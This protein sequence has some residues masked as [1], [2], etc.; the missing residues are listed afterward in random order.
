MDARPL[1]SICCLT[2]N[3]EN[4]IKETLEGF[5]LQDTNFP[6]EV[7]IHDDASTDKT[8]AIIKEFQEKY[9]TIIK[10]IFQTENQF[11]KGVPVTRKYNFSRAQGKYIAMCEGDDYWIDPKKLQKQVDFLEENEDFGFVHTD[12]NV[13]YQNKGTFKKRVNRSNNKNLVQ[14]DNPAEGLVLDSYRIYTLTVLFRKDLLNNVDFKMFKEFKMGDLPL[15]FTFTKYTKF[16]YIDEPTAVY[17]KS[18]GSMSN[19]T[20]KKVKHNFKVSSKKVRLLFAKSLNLK[21]SAISIISDQYHKAVLRKNFEENIASKSLEAF[22]SIKKKS[23]K[24]LL[25]LLGCK[26]KTFNAIIK[27]VKPNMA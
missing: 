3:H 2:Y 8:A 27:K 10:P 9:P 23:L 22:S 18:L 20:Q 4:Y 24:D 15:W 19:P 6:F 17:R 14:Q 16:F 13:Y 5:L 1:V 26:S 11:S 25:L 7:L 21:A 12:A